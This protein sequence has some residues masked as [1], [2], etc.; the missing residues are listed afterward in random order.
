MK[1][2]FVELEGAWVNLTAREEIYRALLVL[3]LDV[4]VVADEESG[5]CQL[6]YV[7]NV[8]DWTYYLTCSHI[9][10][11]SPT[12]D[13]CPLDL[14]CDTVFT[15]RVTTIEDSRYVWG[16]VLFCVTICVFGVAQDAVSQIT[17]D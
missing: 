8:T 12:S 4:L 5:L 16:L 9:L 15:K 1:S 6:E 10:D 3:H 11:V 7:F 17:L 2:V 14:L 13:R